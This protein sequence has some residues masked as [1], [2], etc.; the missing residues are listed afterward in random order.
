M[1]AQLWHQHGAF[2][3]PGYRVWG[4]AQKIGNP[5]G[6]AGEKYEETHVL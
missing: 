3:R 4:E 1:M 2:E 5:V 6:V